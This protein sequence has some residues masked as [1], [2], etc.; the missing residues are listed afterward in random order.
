MEAVQRYDRRTIALHWATAI[1][2]VALWCSA[3]VI[4]WF[5]RDW[6]RIDARSLHITMGVTLLAIYVWR[7]AHRLRNG[8]R[9][10]PAD[11]PALNAVAKTTQYGLYVLLAAQICLGVF[12]LWLRGDNIWNLFSV[13][14]LPQTGRGLRDTVGDLHGTVANVILILAGFH[15][16]AALIHHYL[17]R[18]NVLRR[19]LPGPVR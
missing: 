7:V 13:P 9:L 6:R 16:L 1:L 12:L 2:V 3:Q 4:D 5:P 11:R 19:M 15:A 14:A 17:W 10:P 18:D 8:R